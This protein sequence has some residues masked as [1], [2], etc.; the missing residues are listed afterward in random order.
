MKQFKNNNRAPQSNSIGTVLNISEIEGSKFLNSDV[1][2]L[3]EAI[4]TQTAQAISDLTKN[5]QLMFK[6]PAGFTAEQIATALSKLLAI[7]NATLGTFKADKHRGQTWYTSQ[8]GTFI[9][10]FVTSAERE[11]RKNANAEA[12]QALLAS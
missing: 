6:I 9:K 12:L 5:G 7:G 2:E 4:N 8:N 11:A 10:F 3:Q 1:L